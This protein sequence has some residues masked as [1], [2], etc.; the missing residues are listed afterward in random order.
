MKPSVKNTG[1]LFLGLLTAMSAAAPASAATD[2]E[3]AKCEKMIKGMGA[4]ALH[5]HGKDKTGAPGAM[6]SEHQRCQEILG[7]SGAKK[8]DSKPKQ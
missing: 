6:T 3:K 7:Q 5:D 8:E 4:T 2:Q 1:L